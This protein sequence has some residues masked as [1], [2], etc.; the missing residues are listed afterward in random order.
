MKGSALQTGFSEPKGS[1][2]SLSLEG[3]W[4]Y[5]CFSLLVLKRTDFNQ[6]WDYI[7]SHFH[8]S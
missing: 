1:L 4:K 3:L 7:L 2:Q 5:K 8:I 6:C